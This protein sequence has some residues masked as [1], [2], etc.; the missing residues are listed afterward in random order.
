MSTRSSA[1]FAAR[2][3]IRSARSEEENTAALESAG[4]ASNEP[5][6]FAEVTPAAMKQ[7]AMRISEGIFLRKFIVVFIKD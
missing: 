6:T 7:N 3:A 1:F 2:S 5:M 4:K